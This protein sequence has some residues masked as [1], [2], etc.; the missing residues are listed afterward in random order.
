MGIAIANH[1]VMI[2]VS[3]VREN[4]KEVCGK[5]VIE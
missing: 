3:F 5:T 4:L 2:R 1:Q